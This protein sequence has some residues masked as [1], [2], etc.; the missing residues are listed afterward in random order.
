[1]ID[2]WWDNLLRFELQFRSLL[3]GVP[4]ACGPLCI[5]YKLLADSF[6]LFRFIF[7]I[8]SDLFI[9]LHT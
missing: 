9:L 6:V 4:C 5:H 2:D 1:M 3:M 7:F 8:L